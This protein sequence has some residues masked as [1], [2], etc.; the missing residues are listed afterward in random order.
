MI[1]SLLIY[2]ITLAHKLSFHRPGSCCARCNATN[3]QFIV[4]RNGFP[5]HFESVFQVCTQLQEFS[6]V[7]NL[8]T[9]GQG[10]DAEVGSGSKRIIC[11]HFQARTGWMGLGPTWSSGKVSTHG[12]GVESRLSIKSLPTQT[13]LEF[14]AQSPSLLRPTPVSLH[15]WVNRGEVSCSWDSCVHHSRKSCWERKAGKMRL[16][17]QIS[18]ASLITG[19][20]TLMSSPGF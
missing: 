7:S 10:S 12:R 20:V 2:L 5:P 17:K 13:V 4:H 6:E 1:I 19:P 3:M 9:L 8:C 18:C 11:Q 14:C 16:S 15:Q